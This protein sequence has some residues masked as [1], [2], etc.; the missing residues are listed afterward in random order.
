MDP[1]GGP[2]RRGPRHEA[3]PPPGP[4]LHAA[5]PPSPGSP[6]LWGSGLGLR[7]KGLGVRVWGGLGFRVSFLMGTTLLWGSGL[8]VTPI[9]VG[10]MGFTY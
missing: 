1:L 8:P 9:T 4:P 6:L 10:F 5:P 2:G 3:L 7:V